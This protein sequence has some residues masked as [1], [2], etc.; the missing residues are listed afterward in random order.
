MWNPNTNQYRHKS[1]RQQLSPGIIIAI[2][3]CSLSAAAHAQSWRTALETEKAQNAQ[4]INAIEA[5]GQPMATEL[6]QVNKD[7]ER[8]NANQCQYRQGHP[9]Q[10]A[11]YEREAANLNSRQQNLRT[12]LQQL[13][14]RLDRLQARNREIDI[15]LRCVTRPKGCD[16]DADCNECS[17]CASFDGDGKVR[18]CSPRP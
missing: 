11:G 13:V 4:Q 2:L 14:D 3:A 18:V 10:C 7:I 12:Q 9:E 1:N 16:S 5:Q 17:Y 8:H 6:R 15:R